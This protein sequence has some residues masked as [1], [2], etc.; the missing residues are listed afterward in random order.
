V[1]AGSDVARIIRIDPIKVAAGIPE[2]FAGDVRPG[3]SVRVTFDILPGEEF[4]GRVDFVGS[5]VNTRNRTF[6][7]EIVI[8]NPGRVIKPEMVANVEV[9]RR[10][11]AGAIVVPQEALVRVEDGF[12]AFV[13]ETEGDVQVARVR[14]VVVGTAQRNRVVVSTGLGAGD[15]LIVVGQHQVADGDR[16]QIRDAGGEI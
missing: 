15:R 11:M 10:D 1:S 2:R 5:T 3:A 9:T 6:E 13:A 14:P 4:A 7:V 8:P 12:V 16:I